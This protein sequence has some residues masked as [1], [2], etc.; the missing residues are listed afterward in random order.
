MKRYILVLFC[1]IV[2]F[3]GFCDDID[4]L[5]NL[6]G[7]ECECH[8]AITNVC[9]AC[10]NMV[11]KEIKCNT[12]KGKKFI[13]NP[14]YPTAKI[15]CSKCYS[16][17]F[18]RKKIYPDCE[19][20]KNLRYVINY[21]MTYCEKCF[22][23]KVLDI[24]KLKKIP[25]NNKFEMAVFTDMPLDNHNILFMNCTWGNPLHMYYK[26]LSIIDSNTVLCT[27]YVWND[28]EKGYNSVKNFVLRF[29]KCHNFVD[30][31]HINNIYM[32]RYNGTYTYRSANNAKR[33][34]KSFVEI[35][36]K[37]RN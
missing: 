10:T 1:G 7:K 27:C 9:T 18:I 21:N 3:S 8:T 19:K 22:N 6:I 26:C 32:F 33:T 4:Q 35:D 2:S 5:F 36:L 37:K 34:V 20:C 16:N 11:Y 17:G 31:Q 28:Y 12:C 29:N 23:G 24:N 15:G 13:Y 14:K 25:D 30:E